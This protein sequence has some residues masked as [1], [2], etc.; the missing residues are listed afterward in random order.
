MSLLS[1]LYQLKVSCR[2]FVYSDKPVAFHNEKTS[3]AQEVSDYLNETIK[4]KCERAAKEV[5]HMNKFTFWPITEAKKIKVEE[6]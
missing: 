5:K 6:E 2:S 3:Y 4:L 1:Y